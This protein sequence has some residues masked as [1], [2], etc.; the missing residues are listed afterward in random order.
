MDILTLGKIN[1]VKRDTDKK[2]SDLDTVVTTALAATTAN[3]DADLALVVTN[4]E[5]ALSDTTTTINASLTSL[6]TNLNSSMTTLSNNTANSLTSMG[7]TVV[8]CATCVNCDVCTAFDAFAASNS[9]RNG[10]RCIRGIFAQNQCGNYHDQNYNGCCCHWTAC[11]DT[12]TIRFETYGAGASGQGGCCCGSSGPGA[13]GA[14]GMKLLQDAS[15]C[16]DQTG[17]GCAY[18]ICAGGSGCCFAGAWS[19]QRGH[20]SCVSGPSI[21]LC[22][23]GGHPATSYTCHG[24]WSCYAC[25]QTC[26]TCTCSYGGDMRKNATSGTHHNNQGCGQR[27]WSIA[28][29]GAGPMAGGWYIQQDACTFGYHD[30]GGANFPSGGA[31]SGYVSGTCCCSRWGAGG[32][33]VIT[34]W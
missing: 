1:A 2:I 32:M 9:P 15:G 3:V 29:G 34:T 27:Y 24:Q 31:P 16:C 14:Y 6:D 10:P 5:T 11:Q 7:D 13:G 21:S 8:A 17:Q 28:P 19:S 4:L 18:S 20:L 22:S 33:V 23:T 25:C 26:F 30:H 12:R